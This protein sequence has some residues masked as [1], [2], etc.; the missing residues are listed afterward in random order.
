MTASERKDYAA[1]GADGRAMLRSATWRPPHEPTSDDYPL[2]YITGRTAYHFHTRTKTGR[3]P[4]LNAAA[5]DAWLEIS[6]ADAGPLG[7]DESDLVRV[8]SRR[9]VLLLRARISNVRA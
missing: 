8:E 5:P 4:E 7:I 3:A 6:P 1:V 2:V 9:G